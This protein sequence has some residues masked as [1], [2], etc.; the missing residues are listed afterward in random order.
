M[1]EMMRVRA[2]PA[3][4]AVLALLI[5]LALMIAPV[6]AP[7][8]AAKSC[9][10]GVRPEPCHD[11]ATTGADDRLQLVARGMACLA[12]DFSAVLVKPDEEYLLS[13]GARNHAAPVIL[14]GSSRLG[15]E[16]LRIGSE[17]PGVNF[18]PL[19]SSDAPLLT[20]I[21]RI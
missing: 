4:A 21:L 17:R 12:S 5:V 20:I 9:A 15:L 14:N 1:N 16:S 3:S 8:C 13:A 19:E 2:R 11:M 18:I 10:S 7:L 6:C